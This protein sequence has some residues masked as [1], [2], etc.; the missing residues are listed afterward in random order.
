MFRAEVWAAFH[1][2]VLNNAP[3]RLIRYDNTGVDLAWSA[4]VD[5]CGSRDDARGIKMKDAPGGA[6]LALYDVRMTHKNS[7]T[8][9]DVRTES[10]ILWRRSFGEWWARQWPLNSSARSNSSFFDW[11]NMT[12]ERLHDHEH[13]EQR[14]CA[15]RWQDATSGCGCV[16]DLA[17]GGTN[18]TTVHATEGGARA[19]TGVPVPIDK[20]PFAHIF[21]AA[22]GTSGRGHV[23]SRS[24]SPV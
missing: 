3:E 13:R 16:L 4:F 19:S 23:W 11:L 1:A 15:G 8:K 6:A 10:N 12:A 20:L 22:S 14:R 24:H 9:G 17:A 21:S 18:A 7:N 2:S 5:M